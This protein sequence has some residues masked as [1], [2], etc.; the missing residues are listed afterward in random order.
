MGEDLALLNLRLAPLT[1]VLVIDEPLVFRRVHRGQISRQRADKI[2]EAEDV[3]AIN[4]RRM[5]AGEPVLSYAAT[6]RRLEADTIWQRLNRRRRRTRFLWEQRAVA[7]LPEGLRVRGGLLLLCAT[8][9]SPRWSVD[10]LRRMTTQGRPWAF[11]P[12]R[13]VPKLGKQ[14]SQ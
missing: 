2:V 7:E 8:A 10:H 4:V 6:V 9:L 5:A 1:D 12:A 13:R 11:R 3:V 14:S